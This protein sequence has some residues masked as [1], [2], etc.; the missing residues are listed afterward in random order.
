MLGLLTL[1]FEY[2][3][4]PIAGTSVHRSIEA[5]LMYYPLSAL[6]AMLLYQATNA[7]LYTLIGTGLYFWAYSEGEVV[8]KEPWT[9]PKRQNAARLRPGYMVPA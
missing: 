7:G 2:P 5:R 3:L 9:L 8:C 4:K 1:G 6:A